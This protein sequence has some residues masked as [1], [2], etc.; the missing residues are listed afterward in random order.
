MEIDVRV[1]KMTPDQKAE[2]LSTLRDL[3]GEPIPFHPLILVFSTG[4]VS[5]DECVPM[6]RE[7]MPPTGA[8]F[9]K[10]I[11]VL[12]REAVHINPS[13]HDGAIIF[14]RKTADDDYHLVSWS[15]RIISKTALADAVPNLGSAHNSALALS[16]AREVDCC[17]ILSKGSVSFFERGSMHVEAKE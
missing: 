9:S 3:H 7:P 8:I 12:L 13:I 5:S 4:K 6:L 16:L 11:T 10:Q 15:M 14:T 2:I 17:C 1:S